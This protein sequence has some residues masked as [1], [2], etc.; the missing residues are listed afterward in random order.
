RVG[1]LLH[2]V[3]AVAHAGAPAVG[4]GH[5]LVVGA[6]VPAPEREDAAAVLARRALRVR[7]AA[8]GAGLRVAWVARA[9]TGGRRGPVL[10]RRPRGEAG[11]GVRRGRR[12]GVGRARWAGIAAAAG[13]GTEKARQGEDERQRKARGAAH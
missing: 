10:H 9:R 7:F 3:A 1:A 2:R 11:R 6:D 12:P 13:P 8:G 5:A 4:V